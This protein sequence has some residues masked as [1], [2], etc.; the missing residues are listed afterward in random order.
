MLAGR[1]KQLGTFFEAIGRTRP[2]LIAVRGLTGRGKSEFLREIAARV[3]HPKS[4]APNRSA[5]LE[6]KDTFAALYEIQ[7]EFEDWAFPF[8][9]VRRQILTALGECGERKQT[10]QW[11]GSAMAKAFQQSAG[12]IADAIVKDVLEKGFKETTAV[13]AEILAESLKKVSIEKSLEELLG[14]HRESVMAAFLSLLNELAA[15]APAELRFLLIFDNAQIGKDQFC[16]ALKFLARKAPEKF[17]IVY[18]FNDEVTEGR[19]FEQEH[20]PALKSLGQTEIEIPPMTAPELRRWESLKIAEQLGDLAGVSKSYHQMGM[21]K[22]DRG[23]GLRRRVRA[24]SE[25]LEVQ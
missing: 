5:R 4:I 15:S 10:T 1:E 21:V 14:Q 24:L 12:K 8:L 11:I 9:D 17:H 2:R 22:Q 20:W 3:Q 7:G 13:A 25:V 19:K 18:A 16:S 6:Y 23:E